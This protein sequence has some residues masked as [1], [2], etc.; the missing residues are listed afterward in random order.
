MK[1]V[2]FTGHRVFNYNKEIFQK[3]KSLMI[4]LIKDEPLPFQTYYAKKSK[5]LPWVTIPLYRYLPNGYPLILINN[6]TIDKKS[7]SFC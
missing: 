7:S 2:F 6:K 3:Y 4:Q 5:M 1:S